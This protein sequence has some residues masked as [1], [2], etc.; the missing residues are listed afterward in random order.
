VRSVT[1]PVSVLAGAGPKTAARLAASGLSTV[2]ELL[3]YLPRGYDDLRVT[4]PVA[5]LDAARVGQVVV[6]RGTVARVHIFPR[7]FMDVTI[8]DDGAAL[9]ARWFRPRAGMAKSFAKGATVVLAGPLRLTEEGKPELIHPTNVTTWSQGGQPLGIRARYAA[10]EGVGGRVLEKMIADA[11][12]KYAA[13]EGKGQIGDSQDLIPAALRRRQGLPS[14]GQ[15]WRALHQPDASLSAADWQALVAGRSPAHRRMALEE[16]LVL[17]VGFLARRARDQGQPAR[18]CA[19]DRAAV[20]GELASRLP[21]TLTTGQRRAVTDIG[22]DLAAGRPMQRLLVGDVG[23]GKTVVALAAAVI[24]ARAGGQALFMVPTEV[25]AE[26]HL[27]TLSSLGQ[28]FGLRVALLTAA[29][30]RAERETLRRR[31]GAGQVDLVVGTQALFDLGG[32]CA[33]LRL[34]VIDEQHRF[35]V[36]QRARLRQ[37]RSIA[38]GLEPFE[39]SRS[40]DASERRRLCR[41][42]SIAGGLEPFEGSRS[43]DGA[44]PHLLVMSATPIP[45]SLALTLYGD[46]DATMLPDRPPGRR[47]T[48]TVVCATDD[49][50]AAAYRRLTEA[51][52]AGGQGFVVCPAREVSAR[53]GGVTAVA[54]H[55]ALVRRLAPARV[56][57]LHGA[58][59]SADKD[60]V[61][62]AFNG[63]RLDILVATTV[64]ELGIDVPSATVMVV[65]EAD[66]FGLA[67]LHQLRG[68]VGRGGQAGLCLLQLSAGAGDGGDAAV[69]AQARERLRLL[70]ESDDGFR[71]AEADL[72]MRGH[73]DLYGARQAG[74]P[75]AVFN[76]MAATLVL[77]EMART[78]AT[79]LIAVDPALSRPQHAALAAAVAARWN[80]AAVYGEEAG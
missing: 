39:G 27:R 51:V 75:A 65:E 30:P 13:V 67:Q 48:V 44:V 61:L 25:L 47:P 58:L 49:E 2:G 23:S 37:S 66:R 78:E 54:H 74:A 6:V 79:R 52:A 77:L 62:R 17:Q 10:L 80:K 59:A 55:R 53:V 1:D 38:G 33:D 72:A 12:D 35:G 4:T 29:T 46:L 40:D 68:R 41:R 7:R 22:A 14:L 71:I 70:T 11:V 32:D 18:A 64:V 21:F 8:D 24:V 63:G 73:G 26:Q 57:L 34:V 31:C 43:D 50:R 20:L 60:A 69:S 16:L 9:R 19:F 5:G 56:G 45:R 36:Q 28:P 42:S 3:G 15:A 76:D